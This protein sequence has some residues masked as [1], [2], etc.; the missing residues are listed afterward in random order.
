MI[1]EGRISHESVLLDVTP[2]IESIEIIWN[3]I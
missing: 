2:Y 3:G 1:F